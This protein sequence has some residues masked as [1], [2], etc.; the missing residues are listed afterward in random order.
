MKAVLCILLL[1]GIAFSAAG[2]V[3]T[4]SLPLDFTNPYIQT[5]N[6]TESL[7]L[8]F[9]NPYI[10][11]DSAT[12]SL[13]LDFFNPY[14]QADSP[15]EALSI[16]W[17]SFGVDF[18]V[19]LDLSLSPDPVNYLSQS[20]SI[21]A[22]LTS[23]YSQ[24][25]ANV[26]A[27]ITGCGEGIVALSLQSG[28]CASSC[29][30]A[31]SF[32]PSQNGVCKVNVKAADLAGKSGYAQAFAVSSSDQY[33]YTGLTGPDGI[34]GISVTALPGPSGTMIIS[35]GGSAITGAMQTSASSLYMNVLVRLGSAPASGKEVSV[36]VI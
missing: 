3:A 35:A 20:L 15:T 13:A 30:Y 32:T 2:T 22:T 36:E 33:V 5:S 12:E 6:P 4:E 23:A 17:T 7:Q 1:A 11:T 34:A 14:I 21:S 19:F 8:D 16:D 18:P 9:F 25:I 27:N 10:Q 28:A 26:T 24:E 31:G 29:I